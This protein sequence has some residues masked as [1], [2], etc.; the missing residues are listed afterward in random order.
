MEEMLSRVNSFYSEKKRIK[1]LLSHIDKRYS[2]KVQ[3]YNKSSYRMPDAFLAFPMTIFLSWS[4]K[5]L[6]SN[7]KKIWSEL[8][9]SILRVAT[10]MY[11]W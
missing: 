6:I 1:E 2:T 10:E 4:S 3:L 9:M 8:L 5:P 7:R 11:D